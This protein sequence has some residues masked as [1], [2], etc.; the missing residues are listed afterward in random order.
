V[1]AV[2]EPLRRKVALPPAA[3]TGSAG[4][5]LV[6]SVLIVLGGGVVRVTGSGLGCPTWPECTAGSLTTTHELGIHG[7]IEFGN[8]AITGLLCLTVVAVL[9]SALLQRTPD[10]RIIATAWAQ[11]ALVIVNAVVGGIT[12]LVDLNPWMV[13]AHFIAAM[14]LLTTTTWTWHRLR[15][16]PHAPGLVGGQRATAF[17]ITAL[18]GLLIV[19]GTVT[20]GSGPHSG[21][22]ADVPRMGFDWT[23]V[24]VLHGVLGAGVLLLG[25]YHWASLRRSR[26][27]GVETIRAG[28]FV[29]SVLLQAVIGLVQSLTALPTWLVILH[30]L[31]AALVWIGAV[32][33]SLDAT[34]ARTA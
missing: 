14:G 24:T 15:Q 13:A 19:V 16:L 25:L 29:G 5:A 28:L 18:T 22:S 17:V 23:G 10:R 3:L 21:D 27:G 6:A 31:C 11:L 1:S 2:L 20:T 26:R 33:L 34:G 8:R 7:L 32:R 9:I 4:A 30:V 12:V